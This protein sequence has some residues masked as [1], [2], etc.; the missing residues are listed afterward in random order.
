MKRLFIC[1]DSFMS[2]RQRH[3]KKHFAEI[4]ADELNFDLT[5]YARSG[6]SNGAIS[7]QIETAIQD[8]PDFILFNTT[9]WD[10][11]ELANS[12]AV[13]KNHSDLYLVADLCDTNVRSEE[14]SDQ[15]Y[16]YNDSKTLVSANLHSLFA[17][18]PDQHWADLY[19]EEMLSRFPD[20]LEKIETIRLQLKHLYCQKWKQQTDRML[21]YATLH[22]LHLSNIPY[23]FVDDRLDILNSLYKPCWIE[24]KNIVTQRVNAIKIVSEPFPDPGFHLTY[25]DS[26]KVADLLIGH[27]KQHFL[28]C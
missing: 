21:M 12:I 3:P 24:P 23:I 1:G 8:K 5:S 6:F 22:R 18:M 20:Y 28:F 2:P 9:G 19:I 11:I 25:E 10:R 17:E 14:T 27:Y 15:Y 4:F 13:R 26:Q 7:I 16:A